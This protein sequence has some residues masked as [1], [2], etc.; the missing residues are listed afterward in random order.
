MDFGELLSFL[1]NAKGEVVEQAAESVLELSECAEFLTFL[2]AEPAKIARP[3]IR[4]IER[5]D[6]KIQVA[7]LNALVNV[8]SIP[9]V[10]T[11]LISLQ[12]VRRICDVMQN[13]WT[14]GIDKDAVVLCTMVLS[15]LTIIEAGQSS[16]VEHQDGVNFLLPLYLAP[17]VAKEDIFFHVGSIIRNISGTPEGRKVVADPRLTVGLAR[18]LMIRHRRSVVVDIFRNLCGDKKCHE[19]LN[20]CTF[21][22]FLQ[23]FLYPDGAVKPEHTTLHP[24]VKEEATGLTGDETLRFNCAE[25]LLFL[26]RSDVG[27]EMMRKEHVYECIRAWHL[28]ESQEE[29]KEII[30]ELVPFIHY[31]EDE[32]KEEGAL[33]ESDKNAD[34]MAAVKNDDVLETAT[35]AS[36]DG[37][38]EDDK[39]AECKEARGDAKVVTNA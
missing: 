18:L 14:G 19:H 26:A 7:A 21:L 3:L 36:S 4:A 9:E 16:L 33:E 32:L 22:P 30:E 39:Q 37:H 25:L 27:R 6:I 13:L 31:S 35:A 28:E 17:P 20:A 10:A 38:A 5:D 23:T 24:M 29:V 11:S 12:G 34:A 1:S 15:N 2:R 8:S